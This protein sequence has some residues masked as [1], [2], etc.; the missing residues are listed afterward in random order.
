[1]F[2]CKKT[3]ATCGRLALSLLLAV[4]L[5]LI[6]GT[7]PAVAATSITFTATPTLSGTA[8]LSPGGTDRMVFR[9]DYTLPTAGQV[10]IDIKVGTVWKAISRVTQT[11]P[12]TKT[13]VWNGAV[14]GKTLAVGTYQARLTMP[15]GSKTIQIKILP[16]PTATL[17][18]I[19]P[20]AFTANGSATTLIT[21][22]WT[23]LC[24]VR[25][26]VLNALGAQVRNLYSVKNR[27]AS[28]TQ[29]FWNGR[30]DKGTLVGAGT[31]TVRLMCGGAAPVYQ[32]VTVR[33]QTAAPATATAA[34]EQQSRLVALV[35]SAR[36]A[37]GLS[38]LTVSSS[39]TA[40]ALK[41]SKD[42]AANNYLSHVSPTYGTMAVRMKA[43]NISYW[44]AGENV[45]RT[46]SADRAHELFMASSGHRANI[47]K[48]EYTHI[49]VAFV[50]STTAGQYYITE[51]F[52]DFQ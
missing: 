7:V 20:T 33:T 4:T 15:N 32:K 25:I 8:V 48:P 44:C 24:D 49:G 3:N 23:Q 14:G 42:M 17:V 30:S 52:A 22:R 40:G 34:A 2:T 18:S 26:D 16:K 21:A 11:T 36:K 5:V 35:N 38:A 28:T 50:W 19:Q 39:L 10:T 31:Y 47:L 6:L 9:Y 13:S 1:M 37:N 43:A 46:S 41:H 27:A 45:A 29:V 51:W 12:G